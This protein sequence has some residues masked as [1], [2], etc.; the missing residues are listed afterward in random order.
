MNRLSDLLDMQT[1]H[2]AFPSEI[3][4]EDNPV[5]EDENAFITAL[6]LL[7]LLRQ[8]QTGAVMDAVDR[9][10]GFIEA[11]EEEPDSGLFRFYPRA[12]PS[13]KLHIPLHADLD[14]SALCILVLVLSGRRTKEWAQGV[15]PRVFEKHRLLYTG[16]HP[17]WVGPGAFK[18]WAGETSGNHVDC[19]VN[20]N[21]LAL[22]ACLGLGGTDV[23]RAALRSVLAGIKLTRL[24]PLHMRHL[25]PFYA[26]PYEVYEALSRA[27]YFGAGELA[28]KPEEFRHF[29]AQRGQD[30]KQP[31]CC[32]D[33]GQPIWS[34][35]ALQAA[36][37]L[38]PRSA[39]AGT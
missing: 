31:V 11:C 17:P 39:T 7:E 5:M 21:I 12:L 9:G 18:T 33:W 38:A 27:V 32:N 30:A 24:D 4:M 20:L 15:T 13:A 19:C 1:A 26:H 8:E 37:S 23:Y 2:G 28:G 25:A 29:E 6:V 3:R 36:R 22:Y 14:D 35:T 10:L 34:S 16:G